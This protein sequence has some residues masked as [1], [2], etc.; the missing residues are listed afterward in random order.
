MFYTKEFSFFTVV[1]SVILFYTCVSGS[2]VPSTPGLEA[3]DY[4]RRSSSQKFSK[5]D[6]FVLGKRALDPP[7]PTVDDCKTHLSV[8][9]DKAVFYSS[10]VEESAKAYASSI[11][12]KTIWEA[13]LTDFKT[14]LEARAKEVIDGG[15]TSWTT[16]DGADFFI[17]CSKAF[18][19]I[20]A[21]T[22]T[23]VLPGGSGGNVVFPDGSYFT[24]HEWPILS[25]P[26]QNGNVDKVLGLVGNTEGTKPGGALIQ[27]YP[28]PSGED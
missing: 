27:I 22:V 1:I 19:L 28:C 26:A 23:A 9:K 11:G 7:V 13:G 3:F 25:D 16:E 20:V 14:A 12:G 15:G 5:R 10:A 8:D 21:G 24:V 6:D 17:N 2:V 18:A 4:S